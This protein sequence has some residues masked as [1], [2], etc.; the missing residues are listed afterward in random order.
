M[1]APSLPRHEKLRYVLNYETGCY[2][3]SNAPV[4]FAKMPPVMKIEPTQE[5]DL[6]RTQHLLRGRNGQWDKRILT[7]LAPISGGWFYGDHFNKGKKSL[8]VFHFSDDKSELVAYYCSNYYPMHR[9]Q[10]DQSVR[11]FIETYCGL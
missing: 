11:D 10:R 5:T 4:G 7:G 2:E 9:T 1:I 6:I 8:I 3:L